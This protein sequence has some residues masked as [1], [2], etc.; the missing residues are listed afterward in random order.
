MAT[1]GT[2]FS[3]IDRSKYFYDERAAEN[4]VRYIE[5]FCFHVKG[6][7]SG[8]PLIL[9]DWQKDE[10][11]RPLFGWKHIEPEIITDAKGREIGQIHKR[12]YRNVYI[13]VP[14]KNG[15]STFVSGVVQIFMDIEPELGAEI[16]GLAWGRKQAG[17]I[18]DMVEKSVRKNARLN[19]KTK[20]FRS[21]K[22]LL[23][24]DGN[25]KYSLWTKEAGIEDG[26]FP[27]LVVIDELHEHKN[28]DL[29]DLAEKSTIGRVNPLS[30]TVTTAGSNLTSIGYKR[31]QECKK[32]ARGMIHDESQLVCIYC[33]DK[34]DDIFDEKTWF[35]ANPQL[36]KS[37]PLDDMREFSDKAKRS[38][39]DENRFKRYHLN[40]WTGAADAW[41]SDE[42][43]VKSQWDVKESDYSNLP[44]YG[45]ID[46]SD[47]SDMTAFS[48][49]WPLGDEKYI[50]KTWYFLPEITAKESADK[51]NEEYLR[52][53]KNGLVIQTP[54]NVLD[55]DY[56]EKKILEIKTKYNLQK[57]ATDPKNAVQLSLKLQQNGV[58][59]EMFSQGIVNMNAPT[60]EMKR[61]IEKGTF[62]HL[63]DPVLR[64]MAGNAVSVTNAEDN[65]KLIKKD[66]K[67][68]LKIDGLITNI[69]AL[70]LAMEQP[71]TGSYLESEDLFYI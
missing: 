69:M 38:P 58:E 32:I 54:G 40:I 49:V 42:M 35:K 4:A 6:V 43:W 24:D 52:W 29:V 57:V 11:I 10:V 50:S 46:L 64:W 71:E 9:E 33:A 36:G 14:K 27:N 68:R 8:T 61:L 63:G 47:T 67:R 12:K 5:K 28:G 3:K 65:T 15:K 44:C 62:N 60:R 39:A 48:L 66:G 7:L 34:E 31:S 19:P 55:Y 70:S 22:V 16:V 26:Q 25:K 23:V 45:G 30:I 37:I 21:N 1:Y 18:F 53:V 59:I 41:V 56:V 20:Y 51:G 17:I 13:E 2:D